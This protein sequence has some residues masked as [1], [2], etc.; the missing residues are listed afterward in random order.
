[1]TIHAGGVVVSLNAGTIGE[2]V[3]RIPGDAQSKAERR[4]A[5]GRMINHCGPCPTTT[6]P[7]RSLDNVA[8]SA[9]RD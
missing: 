4:G 6:L 3:N 9:S 8:C 1:M 5:T 2:R 7:R